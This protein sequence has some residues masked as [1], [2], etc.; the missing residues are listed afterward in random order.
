MEAKK[1][2]SPMAIDSFYLET[3][4]ETFSARPIVDYV[5]GWIKVTAFSELS[6]FRI[7]IHNNV[8]N[9]THDFAAADFALSA[10]YDFDNYPGPGQKMKVETGLASVTFDRISGNLSIDFSCASSQLIGFTASSG[11][12]RLKTTTAKFPGWLTA[13]VNGVPFNTEIVKVIKSDWPRMIVSAFAVP[14]TS[15]AFS[16]GLV[17]ISFPS[18]ITSGK[19]PVGGLEEPE[20]RVS[21]SDAAGVGGKMTSGCLTLINHTVAKRVEAKFECEAEN[22]KLTNGWFNVSSSYSLAAAPS[23]GVDTVVRS[24]SGSINGVDRTS[25][26]L[27]LEPTG[28]LIVQLDDNFLTVAIP[29]DTG[30]GEYKIVPVDDPDPSSN[31]RVRYDG[32]GATS[33]TITIDS[34]GW[35][36]NPFIKASFNCT[37]GSRLNIKDAALEITPGDA[38]RPLFTA[39]FNKREIT[40]SRVIV[41]DMASS[42]LMEAHVDDGSII[43]SIR[44]GNELADGS[45]SLDAERI[46]VI[47]SSADGTVFRATKGTLKLS[48]SPTGVRSGT[49]EFDHPGYRLT[50]GKFSFGDL[51]AR[52]TYS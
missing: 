9:G 15:D 3:D 26:T 46:S 12:I 8:A 10:V 19:H 31:V 11:Q 4:K 6:S 5:D 50:D 20:V 18:D 25:S 1:S 13:D 21:Y 22:I 47:Y 38:E 29:P 37:N 35:G 36:S 32:Q 33:G 17:T 42:K 30:V 2:V 40:A 49:F 14:V 16:G 41:V 39:V 27:I 52:P 51:K 28:T 43:F 24:F 45:Y 48:T 7:M 34:I 23:P 44:L